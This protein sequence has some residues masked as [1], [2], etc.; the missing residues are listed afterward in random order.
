MTS[1]K[2]KKAIRSVLIVSIATLMGSHSAS[3]AILF[4]SP[5]TVSGDT[6]VNSQ[7]NL[8]QALDF[9]TSQTVNTVPFTTASAGTAGIGADVSYGNFEFQNAT[10]TN[11]TAYNSGSAPFNLLSGAYQG[12]LI[13]AIYNQNLASTMT[14]TLDG[15][16]NGQDYLLQLWVSDPRGYPRTQSVNG[17]N[18][19]D[20]AFNT[21]NSSGSVGQY[22]IGTFTAT[23][24]SESFTVTGDASTPPQINAMQ[25]R[26]V[27]EPSTCGLV[28][29]G[30]LA[31]GFVRRRR[32]QGA[33]DFPR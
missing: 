8:F 1:K 25:L 3:A 10:N 5:V 30:V 26:A 6:D 7:G 2:T 17:A 9:S 28:G 16:T 18:S 19:V 14:I 21:P 23:G 33:A 31:A 29:G 15:L 20:M 11:S 24:L 12:A 13:G 27:P 4:Q 32:H 22:V